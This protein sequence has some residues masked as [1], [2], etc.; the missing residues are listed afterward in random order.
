MANS[1]EASS[2]SSWTSQKGC[3]PSER[4]LSYYC[5]HAH[6]KHPLQRWDRKGEP[7]VCGW[8]AHDA[9]ADRLL[10]EPTVPI[11]V[12]H[13]QFRAEDWTRSRLT[14]LFGKT[15]D[16]GSRIPELAGPA[17]GDTYGDTRLRLRSLD[18]VYSRRW[19]EAL[20][21]PPCAAGYAPE[22]RQW[23]DWVEP[24]DRSVARWY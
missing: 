14:R 3:P 6:W 8:G 1:V 9:A 13:F 18:A 17:E 23:E 24:R 11:L 21:S 16:G 12:H 19:Q 4:A 10:S 2:R 7:I 15:G 5:D 22:L 20:Y